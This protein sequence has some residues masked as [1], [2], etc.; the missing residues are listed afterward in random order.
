MEDADE[1]APEVRRTRHWWRGNPVMFSPPRAV[2]AKDSAPS[3]A[4]P[5]VA[6]VP[7][8]LD[9][10]TAHIRPRKPLDGGSWTLHLLLQWSR[11]LQWRQHV[12]RFLSCGGKLKVCACAERCRSGGVDRM[13]VC[14]SAIEGREESG[15][16]KKLKIWFVLMSI[17]AKGNKL[18]SPFYCDWCFHD[19]IPIL[20]SL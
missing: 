17:S 8:V 14:R 4:S 15:K 1:L 16:G 12:L 7:G 13:C 6:S 5:P 9:P 19:C 3:A 18:M 20:M 11:L 10:L 2:C